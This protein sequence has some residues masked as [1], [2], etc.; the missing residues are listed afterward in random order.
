M[1]GR[2]LVAD[3]WPAS[4]EE[5]VKARFDR[6]ELAQL[7][8]SLRDRFEQGRPVSRV[9]VGPL[10]ERQRDALADLLGWRRIPGAFVYVS[11]S[12]VD[13]VFRKAADLNARAV[14]EILTGPLGNRMAERDAEREERDALWAW[15]ARHPVVRAEPALDSWVEKVKRAG[16]IDGSVTK[17]R[18]LLERA[19]AVVDA[20]PGNGVPLSAFAQEV[21]GEE[22]A[23]DDGNRLS[24]LVLRALAAL[25][26]EPEPPGAQERRALWERAGVACDALST[27]VLVAG[28]RLNGQDP[29]ANALRI[30][31]NAGQACAVT[32][33]QLRRAGPMSTDASTVWVVENPSVVAMVLSRFGEACPPL[34]CTSGWPSSAAILLLRRLRDAGAELRYHGDFDGSGIRIAAYVCAK[35]G[36][37]PWRMS[38]ADYVEAVRPTGRKPGRVTDAPWDP[39]LAS[40]L[41][42]H[43]VAVSEEQVAAQLLVDLRDDN[44]SR[45]TAEKMG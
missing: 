15:L 11:V 17:T 36:A 27:S 12:A 6:P 13:E 34:V 40:A 1:A 31:V 10:D 14:V 37:V 30:W 32:L 18:E 19:L 8:R 39:Q 4:L 42:H 23:L 20:L 2:D 24:T 5:Q 45:L 9:R 25:H 41:R 44:A 35:T 7:W 33:E 3:R 16:V 29:L 43:D 22:H 28:L 26:D 21:C 38:H